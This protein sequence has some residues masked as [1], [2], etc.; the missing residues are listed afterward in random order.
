MSS[1]SRKKRILALSALFLTVVFILVSSNKSYSSVSSESSD[2]TSKQ[3]QEITEMLQN[4]KVNSNLNEVVKN[5]KGEIDES[6]VKDAE[7]VRQKLG[8]SRPIAQSGDDVLVDN[9][10]MVNN[11]E[12]EVT[13]EF[14]AE[15]EYTGIL[16]ISPV[17]IFSKTYCPYSKALKNLLQKQYE[18]TPLP[19]IVELDKHK[20]GADLQKYIAQITGRKTVPNLVINGVSRGGSDDIH[21]L[22]EKGTLLD[23][24]KE[25]GSK[26]INVAQV[27]APSNS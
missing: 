9:K 3:K 23:N 1:I 20:N 27:K 5:E 15:K 8:V 2:D 16:K 21:A 14:N 18:I 12:G 7:E 19:T 24:L 17:V 13:S 22:H 10:N 4:P 11:K 25:W 26:S 6:R